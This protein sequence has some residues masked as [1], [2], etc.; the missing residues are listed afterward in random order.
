MQERTVQDRTV[1]SGQERRATRVA[2]DG[3]V[4]IRFDGGTILGSGENVSA[5]GVFFT[6]LA[7]LPVTVIIAGRGEVRGD[8]VR[9]E[10]IGDGRIGLAVRFHEARPELVT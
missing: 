4:T 5:Q 3:E 8:L 7:S 2:L 10:T 6:A 1:T 9:L